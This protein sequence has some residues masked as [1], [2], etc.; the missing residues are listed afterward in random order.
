MARRSSTYVCCPGTTAAGP[1]PTVDA[2]VGIVLQAFS[3]SPQPGPH[4]ILADAPGY[5]RRFRDTSVRVIPLWS[6]QAGWLFDPGLPAAEAVR[7]WRASGVSHLVITKWQANLDFFNAR[8]VW[9]RPPFQ[10]ELIGESKL[11]AIFA[12]RALE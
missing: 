5:Q 8:S 2:T 9:R 12:I 11:T 7:R 3:K 10:V 4:V 6:P 1:A